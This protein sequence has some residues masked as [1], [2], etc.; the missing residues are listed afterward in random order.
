MID[1][2]SRYESNRFL[3]ILKPEKQSAKKT[4]LTEKDLTDCDSELNP[5]T[6]ILPFLV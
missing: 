6:I 4:V 3:D 1:P 5:C 2:D